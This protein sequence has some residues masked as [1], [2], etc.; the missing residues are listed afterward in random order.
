MGLAAAALLFAA[1]GSAPPSPENGDWWRAGREASEAG[2]WRAAAGFWHEAVLIDGQE[3]PVPYYET[4][5]ALD[6]LGDPEGAT[7]LLD[8]GLLQHPGE[9]DLLLLR[10]ALLEQQGFV[11]AAE[12]D[13]ELAT[14]RAPDRADAW[15]E[16]GRVRLLLLAPAG[17]LPALQTALEL[18]ATGIE[19][20][21][22]LARVH[23]SLGDFEAAA[24]AYVA[25][26]A[27]VPETEVS[28]LVEA[29]SL[30]AEGDR[31]RAHPAALAQAF[32]LLDLAISRDPQ[33]ARAHFVRGLLHEREGAEARAVESYRR[34]V[35]VDNFNLDAITNLAVIY[36]RCGD[37][38]VDEMVQ[39]A[40]ALEPDAN[41]RRAL[42]GL[43]AQARP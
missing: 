36:A 37:G 30:L 23:R 6:A 14:E 19:P 35:E 26:L 7:A 24:E 33:N 31:A 15:L 2:N 16:L 34:A 29:A 1:C 20:G 32:G 43:V 40:L 38:A 11:R 41:R 8:R 42:E 21:M 18:G 27:E 39:R 9:P 17:A 10:A 4:S 5:R 13:L 22:Y 3:S 12:L 25:A 28:L